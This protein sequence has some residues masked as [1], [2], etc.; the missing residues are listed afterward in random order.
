VYIDDNIILYTRVDCRNDCTEDGGFVCVYLRP[1]KHIIIVKSRACRRSG[2][3]VG[4][5]VG[6]GIHQ[7]RCDR[8]DFIYGRCNSTRI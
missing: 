2:F 5:E 8:L 3:A 6:D 4:R 7:M 1:A